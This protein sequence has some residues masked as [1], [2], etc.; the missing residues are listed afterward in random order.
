MKR[1]GH[2]S[3]NSGWQQTGTRICAAFV[4]TAALTFASCESRQEAAP[5]AAAEDAG[6]AG[7]PME[8]PQE[9]LAADYATLTGLVAEA[10]TDAIFQRFLPQ[11]QASVAAVGN[12]L[13]VTALGDD[14]VLLL[15]PFA[16]GKRFMIEAVVNSPVETTAQLFYLTTGQSK[17][18]D[19]QSQI[20]P[21][22]PGRNVIYFRVDALNVI[23]P[24]RFDPAQVAGEYTIDSM[25]AMGLPPAATQR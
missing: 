3:R 24:I 16:S 7:T 15:P 25:V 19:G 20:A 9:E 2:D 14:P 5:G 10:R 8:L 13:T 22:K 12:R 21:L 23:D 11:Q 6:E 18:R 4:L 17:Y 1:Q